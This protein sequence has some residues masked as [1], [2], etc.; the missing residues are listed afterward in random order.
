MSEDQAESLPEIN[1]LVSAFAARESEY[2][3][4]TYNETQ[5][6]TDFIS[7]LLEALGW[8]LH[9][10]KQLP[11]SL[12]EV[13]EEANVVIA[14]DSPAR[15]PDYELRLARTRKLFVEAKKPSVD[16]TAAA[17]AAFQA[18]RYG[19][20][21]GMPIVVLT[22]FRQLAVYDCTV[23]PKTTDGVV[24][25][26]IGFF[27]YQEFESRIDEIWEYLSRDAIYSGRFDERFAHELQ[28]RG[29]A[30]FDEL[31][32]EQV[33]SWRFRLAVDVH[34]HT[35]DLEPSRLTY[36][37]Q[38]FL[39]RLIFLR[40]CEDRELEKYEQLR[41][42]ANSGGI[43]PY[44]ELLEKADHFYDSGLFN[45]TVDARLGLTVSDETLIEIIGELYYPQSPYTFSVVD[46]DVLGRIY[47]QF[48]GEEISVVDGNVRV[49]LRPEVQES[50]GVVPTPKEIVDEIVDRTLKPLVEGKGPD[51]L[52][53]LTV[54]DMS[55]GSGVFLLSAFDI[56]SEQYL[57]WYLSDGIDKHRGDRIEEVGAGIWRL[58]FSERRRIVL[59]HIRGVDI[60]ADAVE[61]AQLNLFLKLIEGESKEA[62]QAYVDASR[63]RA[64]PILEDTMLSGN[65]LVRRSEWESV[66][67][68]IA[69]ELERAVRPFDWE[70]EFPT[71][72]GEAGFDAIVGNPP[73]IRIQNMAKYSPE[74]VRFYEHAESPYSTA[75]QD[76]F[77]KYAL[78]I[79]R[80]LDLLKPEGR[81][82][83]I[84]PHKFMTITSGRGVR[85][86]LADRV[87]EVVH[88][89]SQPVF[90]GRSNYTAIVI[91]GPTTTSPLAVEPVTSIQNWRKGDRLDEISVP[92]A[93]LTEDPWQFA[94][95]EFSA[96]IGRLEAL[97]ARHLSTVA[98]IFVGL[99]TSADKVYAIS[100][101]SVRER[102]VTVEWNGREW[103]LERALMRPFLY[104]AEIQAFF[105]PE[106]NSWLLHPYEI[107]DGVA[108]LIQPDAMESKYPE[109][110]AYLTVRR[111]ELDGR[112]ITG[113]RANERQ[114]YQYG[115]SQSLTKFDGAKIIFPILSKEPKYA[116]DENEIRVTGGGNG[117][118]YLIRT[119]DPGI[120]NE[121][122]LAV[123]N[124][125][126]AEAIVRTH[127]SVFR[128]GYYSHGKQFIEDILVPPLTESQC[129]TIAR[130]VRIVASAAQA[131]ELA[132]TPDEKTQAQRH[133]AAVRDRLTAVVD[134]CF[135]LS[136]ADH[137]IIDSVPMP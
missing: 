17:D 128:G 43:G 115:R 26:R 113:G 100:A 81:L 72:L 112:S 80:A 133:L 2:A 121:V 87:S 85:T 58:T 117:P 126:L 76:N 37:V 119:A 49:V 23:P 92:R 125:P 34:Q 69:Q 51:E 93:T 137:L 32:L 3:A 107:K 99:Q 52:A 29:S 53:A 132:V 6:R 83:F 64:L 135:G 122:L 127:T 71:E 95:E 19:Y 50:G 5:A 41:E 103:H 33:R 40:I 59:T 104:D 123:L 30:P 129:N 79:E 1:R 14:D 78:F 56:L 4:S 38:L 90:P 55:C 11:Q 68:P 134:Q 88:F 97:G 98:E 9:N 18:R 77:D 45:V 105:P 12:R 47:E 7:P 16:L 84:V 15:R 66:M 62:L 27:T 120:A 101:K 106:A 96:L 44:R 82:G 131:A 91:V 114:W 63:Q 42:I 102:T 118:Y 39:S 61:V 13:V 60:D 46:A 67:G 110:W 35:P 57:S 124:H 108:R 136:A 28:H 111:A 75:Q 36:A 25:A 20:S 89:G 24:V 74:E 8:D 70:T 65:S 48:L 31:F 116:L 109:C 94:G 54:L 86:L 130:A 21:A 22:N 73:Y 10:A